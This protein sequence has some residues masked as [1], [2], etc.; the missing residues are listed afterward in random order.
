VI[1]ANVFLRA[2]VVPNEPFYRW[3]HEEA[4]YLFRQAQQ[5]EVHLLTTGAVVAEVAFMLTSK[6]VYAVDVHDATE[7]LESLLLIPN[8]HVEAKLE[9]IQALRLWA[10]HPSLGFVDALLAIVVEESGHSLAS[11]DSDFNRLPTL[12]RHEWSRSGKP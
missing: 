2:L 9:S 11:F 1:D 3:M 5:G 4:T 8:L 10:K 7:F 6:A 12:V